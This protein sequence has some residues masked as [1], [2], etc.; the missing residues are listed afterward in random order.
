MQSLES[1]VKDFKGFAWGW[2]NGKYISI[3]ITVA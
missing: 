2:E 3:K 1:W